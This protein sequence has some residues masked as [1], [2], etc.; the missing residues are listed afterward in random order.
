MQ[1]GITMSTAAAPATVALAL[2]VALAGPAQAKGIDSVTLEGP[3]LAGPIVLSTSG[4]GTTLVD[5]QDRPVSLADELDPWVVVGGAQVDLMPEAPTRDLG[6]AYLA[7]WRMGGFTSRVEQDVYPFAAGGP[8]VHIPAEPIW[9]YDTRDTWYR[10]PDATLATLADV[11]VIA[12]TESRSGRSYAVIHRT[13]TPSSPA[14]GAPAWPEAIAAAAA[15]AVLAGAAGAT[16][17]RRRRARRRDR[18]APVPL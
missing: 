14:A 8:L 17:V 16:V 4:N 13:T 2:V 12:A 9:D 6:P 15:A 18:V 3:G 11:G 10:V 5:E 1:R 7:T